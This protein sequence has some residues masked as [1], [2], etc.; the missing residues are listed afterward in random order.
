MVILCWPVRCNVKVGLDW[1]RARAE[2]VCELNELHLGKSVFLGEEIVL[3]RFPTYREPSWPQ[4]A[5][6]SSCFHSA[7]AVILR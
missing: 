4:R 5:Y 3:L 1:A 7:E 2:V 6:G